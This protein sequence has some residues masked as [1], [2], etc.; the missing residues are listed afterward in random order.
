M[1]EQ[2]TRDQREAGTAQ[3]PPGS[4]GSAPRDIRQEAA[5]EAA[6]D[7]RAARDPAAEAVRVPTADET[8]DSVRRAQRAL[9]ELKY[10]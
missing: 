7:K 10:R 6:T 8:A 5:E 1:A 2:R 3:P 9:R 4:A